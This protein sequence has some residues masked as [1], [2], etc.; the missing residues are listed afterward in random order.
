MLASKNN[1]ECTQCTQERKR[2]HR[3]LWG[4]QSAIRASL[5]ESDLCAHL[6]DDLR[7]ERFKEALYI[8]MTNE[9]VGNYAFNKAR[10][11]AKQ[12]SQQMLWVQAE[13]YLDGPRLG[14]PTTEERTQKKMAQL[15]VPLA[16]NRLHSNTI[17]LVL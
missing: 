12:T 6:Q 9:T 4:E 13:D 8:Q 16:T 15:K 14:D 2:R 7:C 11:F 17:A 1:Y 3:V 10:L 5:K